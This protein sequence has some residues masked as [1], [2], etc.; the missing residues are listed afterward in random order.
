MKKYWHKLSLLQ[1]N[2]LLT[3]LVI[4]TLVG[5]MGALSFN[6]F[7][8]SMMSI[9]ERQSFETGDAVLN[10]L[11]LEIVR[12]VAKDPTA[13][14]VKKEKLTGQLDKSIK[15]MKSVGQ[16][17]VTGAKLNDKAELQIVALD[18]QLANTV[19]VKPGEYYEQP[20]YWMK[21]YDKVIQT[22]QAQMTE[23]YEDELGFWV[24]ILEPVTDENKN[25]IAIVAADLEASIIPLTKKNFMI[26]GLLFI[27]ISLTI[28]ITIQIFISR[29]SLS[30]VKDLQEGLRKVGEG[31]LSIKLNERSDDIGITNIYFNNTIKKFNRIIDKVRQTAEQV[32]TSSQE[33]S[34]STKENSIAFKEIASAITGLNL[35]AHSHEYVVQ[36]CFGIVQEMESKMKE[37]KGAAKQVGNA[38]EDMEQHSVEGKDLIKQIVNQM[39][40]I[41]DTVQDVP[42]SIYAFEAR[43][44]EIHEILTVI[45]TI[46]NQTNSLALNASTESSCA[47]EMGEE[48]SGVADEVSILAERTEASARD[49]AKLIGETQAEAERAVRSIQKSSKEVELGISLVQSSGAFFEKISES[50][51]SV[52]NQIKATSNHSSDILKDN[53]TIVHFINELSHIANTYVNSSSN[54]E[55][56]MKEQ[57]LYVQEIAELANSLNWLSQELQGLIGEFKSK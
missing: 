39:K 45:T 7:Q 9:F 35:G 24:T 15:D 25:I 44:K 54:V 48:F 4:L 56:S 23:V 38:V 37:I 57:E 18:T 36:K 51:Q 10:Q 17:Y 40:R 20:T 52:T 55:T 50:A 26:Q 53:Q 30:P 13:Q 14:R 6:M 11:D 33:L 31:D 46:S 8:N 47:G 1:K 16:T 41:Q 5:S 32:S 21:T 43:S 2:V 27:I 42:S 3:V 19:S 22:K 34:V 49:I 28:A 29:N 12:D